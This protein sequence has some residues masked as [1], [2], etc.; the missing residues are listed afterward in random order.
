MKYIL[1]QQ[2]IVFFHD[3][4][5]L[6]IEKT[7]PEFNR[8]MR[9]FDLPESEQE[10]ALSAVLN[11]S[12]GSFERD[13][14][15]ISPDEVTFDGERLPK[16]L[17]EKVRSIIGDGLPVTLFKN[18]WLNLQANP[19][20]NSVRQLYD[21]LQYKELPITED[22]CFL[23]YK[24]VQSDGW[25]CH[26]NKNTK[27]LQGQ[28]DAS[29]KIKNNVGDTIEVLRRDVDDERSHHCSFGLH[30]GSL[31]YADSFGSKT[32]VVKVNPADVVS[33]PDDCSCQKCRVAKYE[34]IHAF[35][36]EIDASV[37][38]EEGNPIEA[39]HDQEHK[40]FLDRIMAYIKKK[41]NEGIEILSIQSIQNSFSPDYPSK[42]R[43]L[44]ALNDLDIPWFTS[45]DGKY[46]DI[47]DY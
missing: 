39:E 2:A 21:F 28:V 26:G 24:G 45:E 29:G 36:T 3:G 43:V 7:A 47:S 11:E 34:I 18:F 27:V 35:Q 13:G 32:L 14:F 44:D 41:I 8:I 10:D 38:D 46:A 16:A 6:R 15:T 31:D 30:V 20:A 12:F 5:P 9:C 4:E 22:G 37:T 25:S 19:S 42:V 1:N 33:V 23:A 17:A 40:D